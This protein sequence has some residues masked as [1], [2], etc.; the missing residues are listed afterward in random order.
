MAIFFNT[1]RSYGASCPSTNTFRKLTRELDKEEGGRQFLNEKTFAPT[2]HC[3][4]NGPSIL[5]DS[6]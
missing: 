5:E 3:L 1:E 2:S 4:K 6:Y